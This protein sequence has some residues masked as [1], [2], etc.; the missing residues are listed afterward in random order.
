MNTLHYIYDPFC[1]WC[2]GAAPVV[3]ALAARPDWKL[4]LHGGGMMTGARR[5]TVT[6]ALR[7]YVLGHDERIARLTGQVFGAPYRDGLLC[8]ESTVFDSE[9][10]I[11]AMLAAEQIGG[12]PLGLLEALQIAHYQ[13]GRKIADPDELHAIAAENGLDPQAF[14]QAFAALCGAAT[15]RHIAQS[16]AL[17]ETVGGHGFPTLALEA[18]TGWQQL[19]IQS[20]FANPLDYAASV[21]SAASPAFCSPDGC[22]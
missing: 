10:P 18:A 21:A 11:T 6:P 13:Q 20:G 12:N 4:R 7:N 14:A 15:H 22:T 17:L 3:A 8:D 16:R 19:D 5:Q 2:Y 1:G 9:P